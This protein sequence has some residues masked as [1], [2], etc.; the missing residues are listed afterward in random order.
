MRTAVRLLLL[1]PVSPLIGLLATLDVIFG[2]LWWAY[3]NKR[4]TAPAA[5]GAWNWLDSAFP[6]QADAPDPL[7]PEAFEGHCEMHRYMGIDWGA[8]ML[9]IPTGVVWWLH[10]SGWWRTGR[11]DQHRSCMPDTLRFSEWRP[12]IEDQ[13]G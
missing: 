10:H 3:G 8:R 1:L 2:C 12:F 11:G 4:P 6:A 5:A 7:T 13:D 9:H